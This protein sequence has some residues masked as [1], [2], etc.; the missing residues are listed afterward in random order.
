MANSAYYGYSKHV[1]DLSRAI[2]ILG[3]DMVKNIALSVSVFGMF[4]KKKWRGI[5]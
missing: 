5:I 2:V 3:F 1:G 4:P